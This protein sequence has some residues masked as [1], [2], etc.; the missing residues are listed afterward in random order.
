MSGDV[1]AGSLPSM[2]IRLICLGAVA[3][4]VALT[5]PAA[6]QVQPAGTGEP[7]MV[8]AR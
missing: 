1:G 7:A 4:A 2:R 6:A 5:Q 3:C 8:A